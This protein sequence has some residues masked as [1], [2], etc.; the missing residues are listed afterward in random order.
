MNKTNTTVKVEEG[1]AETAEIKL[2][3]AAKTL[4]GP[5]ELEKDE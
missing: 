4:D 2:E 5:I 1:A 3:E